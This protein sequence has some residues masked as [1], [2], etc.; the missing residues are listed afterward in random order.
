MS[1]IKVMDQLLNDKYCLYNGDSVDILNE[2]PDESVGYSLFSPP[3]MDLYVYSDSERDM[4]NSKNN[5]EFWN[6]FNY[7]I[8]ELYRI[9][10]PGRCVSIHCS[11]VPTKKVWD[12]IIALKDFPGDIIRIFQNNGFLFHSSVTIWKDP[13]IETVRTNAKGLL[14]KQLCKN[15]SC[16]RQG[17]ADYIITMRKKGDNPY[18]IEHDI[19]KGLGTYQGKKEFEPDMQKIENGIL[20][21]AIKD[22]TKEELEKLKTLNYNHRVWQLYAS[23]VWMDIRQTHV[24]QKKDAR[25]A[26]DEKHICPIQLDTVHRCI[27]MWSNKNDIVLDPFMGI[28]TVGYKGLELNRRFAGCELK[29][30]YYLQSVKNVKKITFNK[31]NKIL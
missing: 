25:D 2:F 21:S 4:G 10:I 15:S 5:D 11:H 14:Y 31:S 6:H 23:P 22:Y 13:L 27:I 20:C 18:P 28:G 29:K 17:L 30:S 9:T 8:K 19:Y 26:E 12:G 1:K 24:L 16:S 7:L 3:F